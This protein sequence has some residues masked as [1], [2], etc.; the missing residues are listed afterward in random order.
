LY[1]TPIWLI[2]DTRTF[3]SAKVYRNLYD[4]GVK[5]VA[6]IGQGYVGLPL[7][8]EA[9]KADWRVIGV[10]SSTRIVHSLN[11]G[12]S[13][14]EDVENSVL[15]RALETGN[16]SATIDFSEIQNC[17]VVVM[18]VPTPLNANGEPD[19]S[20]LESA[21]S[22]VARFVADKTLIINESTSF[23]GTLREL[24]RPIVLQNNP[25]KS[26]SFAAA[27]ER[28]DPR[29][30]SWSMKRTPRLVSGI[31]EESRVR[32]L[33]FYSSFCETVIP[34]SSPEV[35]ESAKLLE[36]TF[37]QVNIAL[38]NHLVPYFRNLGINPREVIDAAATKPYGFMKFTPGAGVGG[39]CIPVDPLYLSWA[40]KKDG[41]DLAFIDMADEVNRNMPS[42]VVSRL[43]ELGELNGED[44]VLILG[45]A[46]KAGIS[47]TRE[48]P[49]LDVARLLSERGLK[50]F[51]WDPLV[52]NF[53]IGSQW[54][55]EL[56]NQRAAVIITPQPG[57]PLS[58]LIQAKIPI[59]DCTGAYL[60][61]EGVTQL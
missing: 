7:A 54:S 57:I 20:F 16:Y 31:D 30:E 51:W 55:G 58:E 13:H 9:A 19:L 47:D 59:L 26:F 29:N 35:A 25:T 60:E 5:T 41:Y 11:Q 12:K 49:S 61:T 36:N 18:C 10:D 22:S 50:V 24:I 15:L 39:H 27:P 46:Y 6:V 21:T 34:V 23:P 38:I 48:A 40:A 28:V 37:R 32:V 45:V 1:E 8:L 52:E 3:I 42:Y 56:E 17:E 43:L 53:G 4:L 44:A 33:E 2:L 14:I